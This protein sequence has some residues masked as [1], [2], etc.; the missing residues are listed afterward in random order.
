M[1]RCRCLSGP[2]AA[3]MFKLTTWKLDNSKHKKLN[4]DTHCCMRYVYFSTNFSVLNLLRSSCWIKIGFGLT[5]SLS[6]KACAFA[7]GRGCRRRRIGFG[8]TNSFDF[9]FWMLRTFPRAAMT[10]HESLKCCL[11]QSVKYI[12][13]INP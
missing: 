2:D 12:T 10:K 13:T 6:F 3:A 9:F 1:S 7:F 4:Q 8:L 5:A 11:F